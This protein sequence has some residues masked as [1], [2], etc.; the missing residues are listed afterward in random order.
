VLEEAS[1]GV[2]LLLLPSRS[3]GDNDNLPQEYALLN[4]SLLLTE[5]GDDRF[6]QRFVHTSFSG[7]G[8]DASPACKLVNLPLDEALQRTYD[9]YV[10][11]NFDNTDALNRLQTLSDLRDL[12]TPKLLPNNRLSTERGLP[13][14]GEL[15][16]ADL[17]TAGA[18]P[19]TVSLQRICAKVRVTLTFTDPHW[20]G[21]DNRFSL[22]DAA[23]FAYFM[24]RQE[25]TPQQM[26][27]NLVNYLY[28][29]MTQ[30]DSQTFTG[31]AYVYES[32]VQPALEL[33]TILNNRERRF[34]AR[35]HFPLPVRNR[36]YDILL[37]VLPPL[38][39]TE[40]GA[41]PFRLVCHQ[42]EW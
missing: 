13:M 20:V 41:S 18:Q 25:W 19:L 11:A 14:Y 42:T 1:K 40:D 35:D 22:N 30:V 16:G 38:T 32:P 21:T 31:T 9:L 24:P 15:P 29:A 3:A 23:P 27:T 28:L 37:E 12:T 5:P 26:G 6:V 34:V 7:A 17:S 8:G 4:L 36:L 10:V 33:Y 2:E 39:R